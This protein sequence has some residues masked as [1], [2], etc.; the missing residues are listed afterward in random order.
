[1][2][3]KYHRGIAILLATVWCWRTVDLYA[4]KGGGLDGIWLR[5]EARLE[6]TP[7]DSVNRLAVP[8]V[9]QH[10]G[11]DL[12]C[13]YS[14]YH[15]IMHRLERKF[16]IVAAISI[17]KEIERVAQ[18]EGDSVKLGGVY[19]D[20]SRYYHA[21]GMGRQMTVYI[22]K[23]QAL[24]ERH[25][26]YFDVTRAKMLELERTIQH[27]EVDAVLD[28]M[29]HLLAGAI[30]KGDSAA[31]YYLHSRMMPYKLG[32]G[33]YEEAEQHLIAIE[34]I[35]PDPSKSGAATMAARSRAQL[36]LIRNKPDEAEANY[37]KALQYLTMRP[38]PWMEV[39]ILLGLT[40]LE[41][42][43]TNR[44]KAKT[45][46]RRA[47]AR[48]TEAPVDELLPDVFAWRAQIAETEGRLAE[49]LEYTRK[50]YAQKEEYKNRSAGFDQKNYYLQ[51]EKE[52]LATEKEKQALELDLQKARLRSSLIV[53]LF[54]LALA[55]FLLF[56]YYKQRSAKRKLA[57]QN[58]LIQQQAE[59]LKSLD[60]A[61]SRFFA[62]VSH[63]LRTPLTLLLGPVD[64]L[65][66]ENR[67]SEKQ[68]RLL[69]MARHSGAQLRQLIDDILDLRKMETGNMELH[70][71]PAALLPFFR[72]YAAQFESLAERQR[73]RFSFDAALDPAL[74]ALLD[75]EKCRQILFNLLSNAFKFTPEGGRIGVK[76]EIARDI[77][78]LRVADT[79]PGIHPDD[80]PHVFDRFFQTTRP[81]KP[82]GG[83]TGIGLNL[84]REYAQLFG[85][86]I[87]AESTPDKGSVFRVTFPVKIVQ[88][89]ALQHAGEAY[90][91][92]QTAAPDNLN[93]TSAPGLAAALPPPAADPARPTILVV[94]DNPD[95]QEYIRLILSEKY[96]VV[97]AGHGRAALALLMND[98]PGMMNKN[99]PDEKFIIHHS[100]FIIPDLIL[101]DLMMPLMDGYQLLEKIKSGDATRHIPVIMLTARAEARDRLTALR[102][103][104]D[105]YLTKPFD[106]EELLARID[107]LLKNQE[108]RQQAAAVEPGQETP[109]PALSQPDREWL[110]RFE[111]Y[112]RQYYADDTLTVPGLAYEFAMSE[113]T[114]LR[115][116]KRLTGLT[117]QQYLQEMRLDEARR[118]LENRVYDAVAPVAAKVGYADAGAFS[119][120]FRARFGKLPSEML[121]A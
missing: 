86:T 23:A 80:L 3:G 103:G 6:Q 16:R 21:L 22:K 68:T 92:E 113:S 83:G 25:G 2:T 50:H 61:K 116:L 56:A 15:H 79:G 32:A 31:V 48:A 114:L 119:R 52:Q 71:E 36:A 33:H 43:R 117:P 88:S 59:Q 41:W 82:A 30:R 37:Q 93:P 13:Q 4:Q 111:T 60:A 35:N 44:A 10:C 29:N 109:R 55:S 19:L 20:Y 17:C 62:N 84:C 104:V 73:I 47:E 107:N 78:C 46:L 67:L 8:L 45:W 38:D 66:K 100:S 54:V 72:N 49:A 89:E 110:E 77:L 42:N 70:A 58:A 97:T 87:T 74:T 108:V 7:T 95:L 14:A 34:Q 27:R 99:S 115:Q 105:D 90:P 81:D 118:L 65:L 112:A 98:E 63:E 53:A 1:M 106:E 69:Q 85:G 12:S 102:L 26:R 64:I 11:D 94:E 40:E 91:A 121:G 96:N 57:D 9:R 76:L 51:Q 39:S 18:L 75:R 120:A 101:S 24:F 28:D 5:I